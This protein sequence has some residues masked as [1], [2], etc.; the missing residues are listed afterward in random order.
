VRCKREVEVQLETGGRYAVS[1]AYGGPEYEAVAGF[2]SNCGVDDIQ[3][4]AKANELC[5]RY[6]LDAIST[7]GV[8]AFAMECAEEG[9]LGPAQLGSL[10]LRFGNAAAMVQLVEMI[11]RR[12][13][14]GDLLAEGVKRAAAAIGGRAHDFALHVKG[15]ELP[16]HDPRGKVGLAL[17]YAVSETGADHLTAAQDPVLANPD[18]VGF[19]GAAPLGITQALAPRDFGPAKVRQYAIMEHWNSFEKTVGLCFFGPVPRSFIPV[20]DVLAA[21]R[22]AGGW[23]VEV[24]DLLAIGERATNLARL[25]NVRAGFTR[26]D[27]ALPE[28]L[29]QPSQSGALAGVALPRERFEE[30]LTELYAFKGW[31]PATGV[32]T[33]ERLRALGIAW[34]AENA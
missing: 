18:S 23:D 20:E 4:V 13:G 5:N 2:G 34:A 10:D 7:A 3:A 27:D 26:R 21:V 12:E 17:G 22:A 11:A 25:V 30:A 9:L 8:V 29:F 19:R 32:P 14:I 24:A 1:K 31:D 33:P 16:M 28:R 6:T 15:Q